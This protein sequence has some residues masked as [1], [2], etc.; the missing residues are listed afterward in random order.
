MSRTL[1][2]KQE[3]WKLASAFTISR[4]SKTEA[5]VVV[6]ELSEDGKVGRGECVPYARYKETVSGVIEAI[7]GFKGVIEGGGG[8]ARIRKLMQPGAARNAVDCAIWD[9]EAKLA[10]RRAWEIAELAPPHDVTTAYTL[11]LDTPEKM[12]TAAKANADRPL[13]KLKLAGPE[14]LDRVKAVHQAA[15]KASLIVDANEGWTIDDYKKL[16][17]ELAGLG[18]KLIEQPLP[19]ADDMDLIAVPHPVPVCAE[20]SC[21][22]L[23]TLRTLKGRYEVVNLKLDK[24]G[25]LTEALAMVAE[26]KRLEFQIMVGCMMATS[27]SM[28]PAFLV[29]Q[30]ARFVDLDGPLWLAEDRPHGFRFTGSVM[31]PNDPA[32]WG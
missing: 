21:H 11:S 13:L 24:A 2:I 14:D 6:V 12:A 27:L 7:E 3:K 1:A 17:P 5:E 15:P 18:V 19:A 25:G 16:A 32:L 28:A 20:E 31:H 29:A 26:A 30:H 23:T 4:G 10:G 8:R 22:D 9:L